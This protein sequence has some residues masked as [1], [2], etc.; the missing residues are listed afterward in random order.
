LLSA[1][2]RERRIYVDGMWR[3]DN[4][5]IRGGPAWKEPPYANS[6]DTRM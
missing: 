6:N 4:A 5:Q 2:K 1:R 3:G